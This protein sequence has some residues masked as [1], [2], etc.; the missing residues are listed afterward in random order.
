MSAA[1]DLL[2]GLTP[3]RDRRAGQHIDLLPLAVPYPP[4]S[5]QRTLQY[6]I[7]RIDESGAVPAAHILEGLGWQPGDRLTVRTE[8]GVVVLR[9]DPAGPVAVTRRRALV[10]PAAVRRACGIKTADSVL[11]AAATE[12]DT[13]VVHPPSVLDTMM[14]LYHQH[15]EHT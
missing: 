10:V 5:T 2:A 6:A 15:H 7:G 3:P 13:V 11:L 12:G 4:A 9:R 1:H 8:H 14:T